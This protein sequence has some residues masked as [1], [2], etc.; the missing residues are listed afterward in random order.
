MQSEATRNPSGWTTELGCFRCGKRLLPIAEPGE[1]LTRMVFVHEGDR[2]RHLC[3]RKC[4]LPG[5][6]L[7]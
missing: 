3:C 4:V 5:D 2:R 6:R 7:A 1:V